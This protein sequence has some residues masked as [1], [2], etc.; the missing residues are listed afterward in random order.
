MEWLKRVRLRLVPIAL[1]V[2]LLS[3]LPGCGGDSGD[4]MKNSDGSPR[5][6]PSEVLK[7]AKEKA[8]NPSPKG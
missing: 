5:K 3:A 7:E 1:G 4:P 6:T 2:I 8:A